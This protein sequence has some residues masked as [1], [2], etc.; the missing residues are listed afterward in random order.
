MALCLVVSLGASAAHAGSACFTSEEAQA[1]HFRTMQQDFNVAALNCQSDEA[2][3]ASISK[4]YNQFVGKFGVNLQ[5]NAQALRHHFSRAGGN[6]DAWMTKVA[7]DAGSRAVTDPEYCQRTSDMLDKALAI[8]SASEVESL[9][10]STAST[11]MSVPLCGQGKATHTTKA[12]TKTKAVKHKA[13][14]SQ[15][16]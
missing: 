7:N 10:V 15:P 8:E 16:A 3:D 4:R 11:R 9:A 1:A 5:S 13:K 12:K 14:K 2:D 6:F